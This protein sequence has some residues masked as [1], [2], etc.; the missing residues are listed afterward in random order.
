MSLPSS[1]NKDVV[2]SARIAWN[3]ISAIIDETPHEYEDND[4]FFE[5]Y[6][7]MILTVFNN[8]GEG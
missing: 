4:E 5:F 2:N 8:H 6:K 1:M 7:E 3:K